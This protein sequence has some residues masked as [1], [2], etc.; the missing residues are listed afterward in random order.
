MLAGAC[1]STAS[2]QVLLR[3]SYI[4]MPDVIR[5]LRVS[6]SLY[7]TF[8]LSSK[9]EFLHCRPSCHNHWGRRSSQPQKVLLLDGPIFANRFADSRMI[10]IHANQFRVPELNPFFA[11]RAS[12]H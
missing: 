2:M 8:L 12:G 4:A 11:S 9:L 7:K 10:R 6:L 3:M 5:Q 1:G